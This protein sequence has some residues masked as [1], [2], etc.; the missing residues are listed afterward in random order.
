MDRDTA[1]NALFGINFGLG[2]LFLLV[3][4]LGLRLYGIDPD[5]DRA[6]SYPL[7]YF[8]GRLLLVAALLRDDDGQRSVLGS[9]PVFVATDGVANVMAAASGEVPKRTVVLGSA[10]TA[11]AF[12]LGF[13]A[14]DR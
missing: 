2:L 4:R 9:L 8:G 10:T 7:R 1:R 3:P 12:A 5:T 6:A 13:T 14:R 11:L